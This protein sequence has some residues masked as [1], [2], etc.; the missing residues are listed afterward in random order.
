[1]SYGSPSGPQQPP[2]GYGPPPGGYPGAQ[3]S[4][5]KPSNWLWAAIVSMASVV[6]C[7]AL[8]L[9][10]GI[11]TLVFSLQVNNKWETGDVAGAQDAASKAKIFGIIGLVCVALG[12]VGWILSFVFNA[13]MFADV[14]ND[15][16]LQNY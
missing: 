5:A 8:G 13:Y 6:C 9:I 16:A 4:S 15:P 1:M 7:N 3:P 10:F 2:G 12:I 14:M 11:I